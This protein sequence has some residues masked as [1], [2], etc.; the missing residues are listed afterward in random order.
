MF[1]VDLKITQ[2]LVEVLN[3]VCV[4]SESDVGRE[5]GVGLPATD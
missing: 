1:P 3:Q 4:T 2:Y 5:K